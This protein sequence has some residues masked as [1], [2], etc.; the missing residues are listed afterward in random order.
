MQRWPKDQWASHLTALLKGNALEV[1]HRMGIDDS[2][3]YDLLKVSLLKRYSV[4]VRQ[5]RKL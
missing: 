5:P 4:T 3:D 2:N 1:F